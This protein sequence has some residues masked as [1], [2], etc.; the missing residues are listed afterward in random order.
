MI[1][2]LIA[3]A[4]LAVIAFAAI[5]G[6]VLPAIRSSRPHTQPLI[7]GVRRRQIPGLR[8]RSATLNPGRYVPPSM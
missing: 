1:V 3:N 8:A 5:L 7:G 6:L 2:V 4:V